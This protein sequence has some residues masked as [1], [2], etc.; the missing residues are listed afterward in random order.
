MRHPGAEVVTV[1]VSLGA[2]LGKVISKGDR[3]LI[4]KISDGSSWL[5]FRAN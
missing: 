3:N 4:T 1:V 2:E 5:F